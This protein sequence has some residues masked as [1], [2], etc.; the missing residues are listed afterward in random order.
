MC[1]VVDEQVKILIVLNVILFFMYLVLEVIGMYFGGL[2][3]KPLCYMW[4]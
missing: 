4:G 1:V 3:N 2:G